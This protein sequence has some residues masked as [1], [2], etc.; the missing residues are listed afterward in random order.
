MR[1][2]VKSPSSTSKCGPHPY[3]RFNMVYPPSTG[4]SVDTLYPLPFRR[5][6]NPTGVPGQST[7]LPWEHANR[8]PVPYPGHATGQVEVNDVVAR[9]S[10]ATFRFIYNSTFVPTGP[11]AEFLET[12]CMTIYVPQPTTLEWPSLPPQ[13][14][15]TVLIY[16]PDLV[17]NQTYTVELPYS[18]FNCLISCTGRFY[19]RYED[20]SF[21]EHPDHYSWSELYPIGSK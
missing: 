20:D 7:W 17:W 16:L 2:V 21:Y 3:N 10:N 18:P 4:P 14:P 12:H 15:A 1:H 8:G 13:T 9:Y 19:L 5:T 11:I 6:E